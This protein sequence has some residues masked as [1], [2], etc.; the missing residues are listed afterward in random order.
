MP[1]YMW[2]SV[3]C[4]YKKYWILKI[5]EVEFSIQ[6]RLL[7]KDKTLISLNDMCAGFK[8]RRGNSIGRINIQLIL[9]HSGLTETESSIVI[10][11]VTRSIR[12]E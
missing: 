7:G 2:V 4:P 6:K 3:V 10:R 9:K 1:K 12:N 11:N 8:K 5:L